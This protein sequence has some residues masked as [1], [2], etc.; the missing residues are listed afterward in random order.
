M[1]LFNYSPR[2]ERLYIYISFTQV[3]SSTTPKMKPIWM[4]RLKH[5]LW[6]FF[7]WRFIHFLLWVTRWDEHQTSLI[8][9]CPMCIVDLNFF[10]KWLYT[11]ISLFPL[12]YNII[13]HITPMFKFKLNDFASH[14][15][16]HLKSFKTCFI[17]IK[18]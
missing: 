17:A 12:N 11:M 3:Y 6:N 7:H 8:I 18:N 14:T 15:C 1:H 16:K 13:S 9:L 4:E 2:V 10:K 5:C